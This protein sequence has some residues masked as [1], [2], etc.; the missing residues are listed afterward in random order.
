MKKKIIKRTMRIKRKTCKKG[1]SNYVLDN[2]QHKILI[3]DT[4]IIAESF[5]PV[6]PA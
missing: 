3:A 4:E 1:G 2:Y 6:N 5:V